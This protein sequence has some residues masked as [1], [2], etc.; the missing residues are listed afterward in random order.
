MF[1][2]NIAIPV[3]AVDGLGLPGWTA[4]A[5]FTLNTLMVGFGQGAV[6]GRLGGRMRG[7]G[8]VAGHGC[9]ALGHALFLAA[10]GL[11]AP[12]VAVGVVLLGAVS[13]TLG[14]IVGGPVASTVAAE[15]APDAL[16]AGTWPSCVGGSADWAGGAQAVHEE[17]QE[18]GGPGFVAG[19]RGH[20]ED[21]DE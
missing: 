3:Y 20:G 14:E 9:F 11:T 5:V 1:A 2:L 17:V 19:R 6:V 12:A 8:L 16:R 7:R 10:D 13:C 18:A 21:A 15:S 4:G